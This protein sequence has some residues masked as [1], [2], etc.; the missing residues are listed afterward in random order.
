MSYFR[1]PNRLIKEME[2]LIRRFWWGQGGNKGKMQLLPWRTLC[3]PKSSGGIG[4]R[5][6]GFFNEALLA[7]QV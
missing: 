7:K 1:L 2:V 3:K 5:D 4:L 6:L